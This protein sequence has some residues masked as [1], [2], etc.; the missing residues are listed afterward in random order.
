MLNN[1]NCCDWL[2]YFTYHLLP[3]R[4]KNIWMLLGSNP[5]RLNSKQPRYPLLHAYKKCPYCQTEFC[6]KFPGS[7]RIPD[8]SKSSAT[9]RRRRWC[10]GP[11]K[12][13]TAASRSGSSES[14]SRPERRSA[15]SIRRPDSAARCLCLYLSDSAAKCLCLYLKACSTRLVPAGGIIANSVTF[16][17]LKE[18]FQY[19]D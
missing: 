12:W 7:Y 1:I 19:S 9:R 3:E 6:S 8:I 10:A 14:S 13:S 4:K 16:L 5:G 11:T 17:P 18:Q 2:Q 15:G